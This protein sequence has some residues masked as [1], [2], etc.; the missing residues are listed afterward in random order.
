M[1]QQSEVKE[2]DAFILRCFFA[3]RSMHHHKTT[4]TQS[5]QRRAEVESMKVDSA[6]TTRFL[7]DDKELSCLRRASLSRTLEKRQEGVAKRGRP[8]NLTYILSQHCGSG[9]V[10]A[11]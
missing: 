9:R 8:A 5:L 1:G 2:E 4:V 11:L 10:M 6:E 3:V 7:T